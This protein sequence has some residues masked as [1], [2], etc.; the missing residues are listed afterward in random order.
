MDVKKAQRSV[1]EKRPGA[2]SRYR[3]AGNE[4]GSAPA[5][6]ASYWGIYLR[7][8]VGYSE[9]ARGTTVEEAWINAS[10]RILGDLSLPR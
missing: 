8:E 5:A 4:G 6:P 9:I 7:D 10:T 1:W 3:Q 2:V